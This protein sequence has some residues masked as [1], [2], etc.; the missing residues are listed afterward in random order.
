[1]ARAR[2]A[3]SRVS[4]SAR[5]ALAPYRAK[6]D[7]AVTAEPSGEEG[8]AAAA[9]DSFVI[10]KHDA[11]RLHYDF[12]L[13]HDGVLWSW[14]VPK[15]PSLAPGE[16]RLAVRTED[17]PLDY[18]DFEGIIPA[19]EYGGGTVV[20]W[21]R[22]RWTPSGDAADGMKRGRLTFDLEGEKLRGRW[23]LVRT[24][25]DGKAETWLLFKGKDDAADAKRDITAERPDSVIS[26]RT[27]EEVAHDADRV[28]HSNRSQPAPA[29]SVHDLLRAL[30]LGYPLTNLDKILYPE[31]GLTKGAVIAYLAVVA[32]WMLP[33]VAG[34]P[35]T[36]V[37]CPNGRKKPCFFQKHLGKGVPASIGTVDVP[38][39]DGEVEQYM[40]V[41]DLSGLVGL[42]Q[43]GTLEIHTWAGRADQLERPDRLV[44]DLDPDERVAWPAVIDAAR[45]MRELLRG[46]GLESFVTTTGGKGLH[47][48]APLTRRAGWDEHKAFA[49]AVAGTMVALAPKLYTANISKAARP[50][51]IFVDYL[52]NG[53]GATFI[54]PYSMRAR[55]G[56][57]VATPLAWDEL[58]SVI[59]AELTIET[60]PRRLGALAADPWAELSTRRQSITA[61]AWR[62]L[63]GRPA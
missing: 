42:A 31:Q 6:R 52:R 16:R 43:L 30:P 28:W 19:G 34:R 33:H 51:K 32:D 59:P 49:R 57:T 13:E 2:S 24:R 47:V 63:G 4:A 7:F 26:G 11:S 20:V 9:G 27:V 54:A 38:G 50:G 5:R 8:R 45:T 10:Q 29:T 58:A 25:G 21:D 46:L 48:V 62:R 35:L 36:L 37:R 61:A 53:R 41:D 55:A 22:G 17:H 56:A 23:H 14:S 18:A 60:V 39:D 12:R 15:G 3:A 1:M 40:R 44:M